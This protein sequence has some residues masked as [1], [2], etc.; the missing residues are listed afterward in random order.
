MNVNEFKV[1]VLFVSQKIKQKKSIVNAPLFPT[2][3]NDEGNSTTRIYVLR[4]KYTKN[5]LVW[6]RSTIQFYNRF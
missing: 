1:E 2:V 5:H 4:S 3:N 6:L